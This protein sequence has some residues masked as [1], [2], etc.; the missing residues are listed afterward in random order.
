MAGVMEA[1]GFSVV[2]PIKT[3]VPCSMAGKSES[4]CVLL[5]RW[6]SSSSR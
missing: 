2:E 3:M 4:D 6:H 1:Y 5:K